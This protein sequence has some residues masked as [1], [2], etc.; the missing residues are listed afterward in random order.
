MTQLNAIAG[1][2]VLLTGGAGFLGQ[3]VRAAL[4]CFS[5][6]SIFVPRSSVFDLRAQRAI[7]RLFE[8]HGPVDVVIHLAAVVGGIGANRQNPGR[9]FYDNAIMGIQLMEH[10]TGA[11][12]RRREV[13][14]G[15]YDL[16]VP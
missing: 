7:E 8:Q 5:P 2:H 16:L 14:L 6:Q 13:R 3:H 4:E 11:S 1:K 15:R 12:R 10:G 9:F